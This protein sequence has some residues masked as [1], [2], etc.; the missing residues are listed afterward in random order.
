[1]SE[2]D[3]GRNMGGAADGAAERGAHA[4]AVMKGGQGSLTMVFRRRRVVRANE[5]PAYEALCGR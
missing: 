5:W 4:G 2:R 1:M 3:A